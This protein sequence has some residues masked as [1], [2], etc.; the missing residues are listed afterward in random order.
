MEKTAAKIAQEV[1]CKVVRSLLNYAR[2]R[3]GDEA[4][5][6]LVAAAD[7]PLEYLM[8]ENNWV[9]FDVYAALSVALPRV[10][11]DPKAMYRAGLFAFSNTEN[12]GTIA[13]LAMSFLTPDN[14]YKRIPTVANQ[15]VRFGKYEVARIEGNRAWLKFRTLPGFRFL[16]QNCD[17]RLGLF[18]GIPQIFGLPIARHREI[19]CAQDGH[20]ECLYEFTW[21]PR[22]FEWFGR[23]SKWGVVGILLVLVGMA[24]TFRLLDRSW[25]GSDW[26][27]AILGAACVYLLTL[28]TD[29][30]SKMRDTMKERSVDI[31]ET[32]QYAN[33]KYREAVDTLIRL[34]AV[35]ETNAALN[36]RLLRHELMEL[37]LDIIKHKLGFERAMALFYD[38]ST[39][40]F[41]APQMIGQAV[42]AASTLFSAADPYGLH[43][44][45]FET[46]S[47]IFV[48]DLTAY[49]ALAAEGS[50]SFVILPLTTGSKPAGTLTVDTT[51]GSLTSDDTKILASL[52]DILS[53]AMDNA[54]L[55]QDLEKRV[56]ERTVEVNEANAKLE[57]ALHE[58]Q[59]M[60]TQLLH[61][62]KMASIG[63]LVAGIAHEI[64]NP[65]G[66]VKGNLELLEM[67]LE[68]LR[69]QSNHS[70][71]A[72]ELWECLAPAQQALRRIIAVVQDLRDFSRVDEAEFK[73]A[74]INDGLEDTIRF[75]S[76]QL[77]NR[78]TIRKVLGTIP[79]IYCYP[80][81]LNQAMTAII[82]NSIDSITDTGTITVSTQLSE[83]GKDILIHVEDTGH[84]IPEAIVEKIFDPF[85]TTKDVGQGKGLGLSIAYGILRRHQ[86]SISVLR[87]GPRGTLIQVQIPTQN[88]HA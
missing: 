12:F 28:V 46:G 16:K 63:K 35:I 53:V 58:L 67:Q 74:N 79:A 20:P 75:L 18:A 5:R 78:I 39:E 60:Q 68:K 42:S 14:L 1:N 59:E 66:I 21:T 43:R 73:L 81:H 40:S 45:V 10:L 33:E 26:P 23:Y 51:R 77:S 3:R 6:Q 49:P 55:Y 87:S 62:E 70:S 56:Q 31:E 37:V 32:I 38:P 54:D 47:P 85:F 15:A 44:R 48:T 69:N 13:K 83:G 41:L 25:Q 61:T 52:C 29:Q 2:G 80:A 17:Y 84:G 19:Q 24:A 11:D 30:M 57:K 50:T 27:L 8:N 86:G 36:T 34:E 22:A 9:S 65:A 7:L 4:V 64:N 76:V 72:S 71:F 82:Q 88:A